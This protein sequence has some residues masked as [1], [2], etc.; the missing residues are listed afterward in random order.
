MVSIIHAQSCL[1]L[2][3]KIDPGIVL[4]FLED[5]LVIEGYLTSR[6]AQSCLG[7]SIK[8][9]PGIVLGF[10]EVSCVIEGY[11]TSRVPIKTRSLEV[12]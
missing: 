1:G 8:I 2:S 3:I 7:L 5:S 6:D 9:N 11:L 10:L 12:V 4:G